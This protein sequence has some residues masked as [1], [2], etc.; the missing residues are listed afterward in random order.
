M[1]SATHLLSVIELIAR[2][3]VRGDTFSSQHARRS[4]G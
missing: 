3:D 1:A 2:K 4:A